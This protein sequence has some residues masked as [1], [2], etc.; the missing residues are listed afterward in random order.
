VSKANLPA[1]RAFHREGP[2][3]GENLGVMLAR[4]ML[5]KAAFPRQLILRVPGS[6]GGQH[7]VLLVISDQD[8]AMVPEES[9]SLH[10]IDDPVQSPSRANGGVADFIAHELRNHLAVTLG[11]AQLLEANLETTAPHQ[12]RS[13]LRSILGETES[14]LLVLE[15]LLMAVQARRK[16]VRITQVPLH[17]VLHRIIADHK[18]RYPDRQFVV[19]GD[20]PVFAAGNSTWIQIALANLMNNAEKVTPRGEPIEISLRKEGEKVI[21]L[22][23]DQGRP[24]APSLYEQLWD[25]YSKGPPPGVEITGS[26]IGLSICKELVGSMGGS[27]WAGPRSRGGSA[28]AISLPTTLEPTSADHSAA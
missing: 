27:V 23:L 10:P 17:S 19:V 20:S 6:D 16:A 4:V 25:V 9:S 12:S 1:R 13:V 15:G 28:F 26:G 8:E 5:G 2:L 11:L 18:R 7:D 21:I 24:L 22:V 14:S 3:Q